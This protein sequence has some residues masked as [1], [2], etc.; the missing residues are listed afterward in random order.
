MRS[1]DTKY[2][3]HQIKISPMTSESCFAIFNAHQKLPAIQYSYTWTW[4]YM[5]RDHVF[6]QTCFVGQHERQLIF[7]GSMHELFYLPSEFRVI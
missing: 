1:Y 3:D 2:S 4:H 7:T 6:E 5:L